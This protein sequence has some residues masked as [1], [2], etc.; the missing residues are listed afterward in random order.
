M[1]LWLKASFAQAAWAPILVFIIYGLAAKVFGAYLSFPHLDIPT[2]FMGGVAITYFFI[3]AIDH[4]QSLVGEIPRQ[5]RAVLALGLTA[6][7]AVIWEFL[8][9][10]S[11][12]LFHTKMNLGVQDTLSDLFFGLLGAVLF[13]A[14][15]YPSQPSCS[16]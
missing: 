15:R 8:E 13:I 6:L 14:F 7:I 4:G 16:K 1:K 3:V 9:F 11:D 12:Q 10:A 5:V 2:H